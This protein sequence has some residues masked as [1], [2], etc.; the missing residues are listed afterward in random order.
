MAQPAKVTSIEALDAFKASLI[1]YLEK[2]GRLLDE[3]S[4]D[5]V[6]TRSWLETDRLVHWKKQVHVRTRA[7]AQADQELLTARLSGMPEAVQTR[8]MAVNQAKLAL[9]EAEDG[10]ARVR[11][12]IRHYET[13]AQS[14]AKL[15]TQLRHSLAFDMS[16]AVAFLERAAA[17][18]AAYG[19]MSPPPSSP[20]TVPHSDQLLPPEG[21]TNGAPVRPEA[22]ISPRVDAA[23]LS[24]PMEDGSG[25]RSTAME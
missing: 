6:R 12:W 25:V 7:L 5:V 22:R 14:H 19:E 24:Q 11:Q 3:V 15:V 16:K 18:L 10:L 17:T 4:E 20:E 1:V 13:Q 8:R 9:R 2:A 23:P 21:G